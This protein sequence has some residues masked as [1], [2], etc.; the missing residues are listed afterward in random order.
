MA[1]PIPISSVVANITDNDVAGVAIIQSGGSTDVAEGGD[2]DSYT[3]KLT[4]QPSGD[5]LVTVSPDA[6]VATSG[7]L[8]L[9]SVN[10]STAQTVTVTA[11]DDTVVEG[12]HV[13]AIAHVASGGG[14]DGAGIAG[15]IANISDDDATPVGRPQSRERRVR[16][17]SSSVPPPMTSAPPAHRNGTYAEASPPVDGSERPAV[18]TPADSGAVRQSGV[19]GG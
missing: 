2:T 15:V 8:V 3:L 14:Y 12:G 17:T 18:V 4:A 16:R 19:D 5:V 13:G 6:Q 10:W 1:P 11:V 9:T 7:I